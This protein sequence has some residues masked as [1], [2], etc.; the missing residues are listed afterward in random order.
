LVHG[1]ILKSSTKVEFI[2]HTIPDIQRDTFILGVCGVPEEISSPLDDGWF[3][4]DFY[5]FNYLLHGL[6]VSQKWLA[7]SA[8]RTLIEKHGEYMDGKVVLSY[9]L[10]NSNRLSE[11]TAVSPENILAE[12]LSSLK[13]ICDTARE[14]KAPVLVFV[15]GHGQRFIHSVSIGSPLLSMSAF[16][17]A[18]GARVD[19]TLVNTACFSGGWSVNP[20]LNVTSLVAAG[21][22]QESESWAASKSIGGSI[23]A[24]ALIKPFL[25]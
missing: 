12:F 21:P 6:G 13:T 7:C 25:T 14:K 22:D 9:P 4:A 23:Y 15:F 1:G 5:A 24:T 20:Q 10:L 2:S 19:V 16:D 3:I 17:S 11:V 18:I 8:P